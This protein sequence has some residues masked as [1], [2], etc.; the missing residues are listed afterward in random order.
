MIQLTSTVSITQNGENPELYF[1]Q[2]IRKNKKNPLNRNLGRLPSVTNG[3]KMASCNNKY[4][5]N[6][7]TEILL[8][9]SLPCLLQGRL[10]PC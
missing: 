6:S 9:D 7:K 2:Y 4:R 10:H 3:N 5:K 1:E 8:E